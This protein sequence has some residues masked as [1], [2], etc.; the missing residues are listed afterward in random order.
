MAEL[1]WSTPEN[2]SPV[3]VVLASMAIPYFHNPYTIDNIPEAG[4]SRHKQ[5]EA[6][7]NYHDEVPETV[8]FMDGSMIYQPPFNIFHRPDQ[9]TPR[10]PT[11]G[12]TVSISKG[13]TDSLP[14]FTS[15]LISKSKKEVFD[16]F[17]E[18]NPDC[19]YLMSNININGKCDWLNFDISDD[20][21]LY[22]FREGVKA[23]LEFLADFN[24]QD[25][26]RVRNEGINHRFCNPYINARVAS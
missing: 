17:L 20:N 5:W 23:G 9:I 15:S 19:K 2:V 26:K 14:G 6:F 18:E 11:F 16:N 4:V 13:E 1:Y 21:K 22:L 25:Y 12:A 3:E 7:A 8:R 10:M 24:W